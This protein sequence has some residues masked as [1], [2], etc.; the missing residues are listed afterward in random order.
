M[1][2]NFTGASYKCYYV[3]VSNCL[4]KLLGS[5]IYKYMKHQ[6]PAKI[7][8]LDSRKERPRKLGSFGRTAETTGM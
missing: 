6:K 5:V 8:R 1:L 2:T 7:I 3:Y 4:S